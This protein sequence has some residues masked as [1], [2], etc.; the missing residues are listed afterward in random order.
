[1][2][3]LFIEKIIYDPNQTGPLSKD[4]TIE[5]PKNTLYIQ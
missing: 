3:L 4:I 1:M 2:I 5:I